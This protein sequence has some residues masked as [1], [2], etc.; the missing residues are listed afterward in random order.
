APTSEPPMSQRPQPTP[1]LA[2]LPLLLGLLAGPAGAADEKAAPE[3]REQVC[4]CHTPDASVVWREGPDKPWHV[5]R[6]GD[7]LHTGDLL[8]ALPHT[9]LDLH[10]GVRLDVLADLDKTTPFPII[11]SAV[12]LH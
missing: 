6:K 4:S 2:L 7:P 3:K 9:Y 1:P 12:I 11:E 5:A 8:V 10:S